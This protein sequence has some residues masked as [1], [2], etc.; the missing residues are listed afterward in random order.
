MTEQQ[1]KKVLRETAETLTNGGQIFCMA[2]KTGNSYMV[3]D[4]D[5]EEGNLFQYFT[6][7]DNFEVKFNANSRH[8]HTLLVQGEVVY[9]ETI[10]GNV[11]SSD[12]VCRLTIN[13]GVRD[14][15]IEFRESTDE[16]LRN[17]IQVGDY[18]KLDTCVASPLVMYANDVPIRTKKVHFIGSTADILEHR[19]TISLKG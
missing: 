1:A 11:K 2:L 7:V 3:I 14:L 16:Y 10:S 15:E 13:D 6:G 19:R 18:L 12:G 17:K 8:E 5:A 4:G 9:I